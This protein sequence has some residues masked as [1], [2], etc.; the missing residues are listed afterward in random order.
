MYSK[1]ALSYQLAFILILGF[2]I[3]SNAQDRIFTYTYQSNVLNKG[4][5]ELEVWNTLR[6]GKQD[7][8]SRLDNRTEFEVGLGGNLQTSFYL[9]LTTITRTNV[10][11]AQKS[12]DTKHEI[13]FSNEWKLKLMDPVANPFGLALY[14]EYGISSSEYELE[15]K[16]IIDKKINNLTIAGNATYE[17][18]FAPTY[19][20][21]QLKWEK[22]GKV[23]YNL[24]LGYAIGHG[25]HLT[26]ENN[27]K[28][29][30]VEKELEHSALYSG[31]GFAYVRDNFWVNFTAMPQVKSFKGATGNKLNLNE[32]EKVQFRLLFSY[33]F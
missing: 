17:G 22:E 13:G 28:N 31:L 18:E 7:F 9:N 16:I 5:R 24:A 2:S 26:Q 1:R 4:Q 12:T 20:N 23:D 19:V 10:E 14:G 32:F 33:A 15:G 25:F 11:G 21:N 3:V 30:Y 29:V 27:I 6:Q 8:F